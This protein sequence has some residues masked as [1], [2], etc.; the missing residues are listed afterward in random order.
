MLDSGSAF[1]LLATVIVGVIAGVAYLLIFYDNGFSGFRREAVVARAPEEK[2]YGSMSTV[3][4]KAIDGTQ[5]EG[6]LFQPKLTV[7]PLV[8]MAPGLTGTKESH[9][10]PFAWRFV[11]E[12]LAVLAIDFRCFGGSEGEPR[13]WVDP[14]RQVEDYRAAV[15]FAVEILARNG[16]IDASR[17]A[18]WGSSFSGGSALMAAA[19][20][21][22]VSA[23]V[24]QCPFLDTPAELTP[25][26][27][28]M[29]RYVPWTTLDLARSWLRRHLGVNLAPVYI[30]AFGQPGELCFAKSRENPS[31]LDPSRPGT[32]FWQ[33]LSPSLRGGWENKLVARFLADFDEFKPMSK[34]SSLSCPVYLVAAELDDMVPSRFVEEAAD[35]LGRDQCDLT[36][37]ACGHFDL[38]MDPILSENADLQARFLSSHLG[39]ETAEAAAR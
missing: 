26:R 21:S 3:Y 18:L 34:L 35:L 24:A 27:A 15:R 9:L 19:E 38:Y 20:S 28:E 25:T 29:A 37:Y 7:A 39:R 8:I 31:I 33:T 17:I 36:M 11:R 5:I 16:R 10:E 4:L 22:R 14:F 6:W 32:R 2:P 1:V 12:G 23:V 13:H 30:P